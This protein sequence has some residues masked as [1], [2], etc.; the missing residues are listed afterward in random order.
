[1][2]HARLAG[3]VSPKR[4]RPDKCGPFVQSMSWTQACT[5]VAGFSKRHGLSSL[6]NICR[7]TAFMSITGTFVGFDHRCGCTAAGRGVRNALCE[8]CL[9]LLQDAINGRARLPSQCLRLGLTSAALLCSLLL[10]CRVQR[11]FPPLL[12]PVDFLQ[13]IT[14]SVRRTA[15]IQETSEETWR[16]S[17]RI[18]LTAVG[19]RWAFCILRS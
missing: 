8:V 10:L 6:Q 14:L 17:S 12:Q 11:P 19:S 15:K 3:P 16:P 4:R 5:W 7:C 1:M 13:S 2:S 18:L 9:S